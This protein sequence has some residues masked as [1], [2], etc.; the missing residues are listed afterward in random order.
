MSNSKKNI[1][2]FFIKYFDW[3]GD[4]I[5]N[6]WEYFIPFSLVLLMEILAEL[7]A[8]IIFN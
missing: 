8:K 5:T 3:N 6:W 1:K 7:I 2:K 4:G